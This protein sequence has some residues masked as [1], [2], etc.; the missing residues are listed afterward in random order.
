MNSSKSLKIKCQGAATQS[1]NELKDLQGGLKKLSKKNLEK[2]KKRIVSSG[3]CAPFFIW[4]DG[5]SLRIIDGHQR[6][7]ALLSLEAD[8]YEI[9]PLP[10]DYIH[11]ETEEEAKEILLSV[12]SQYGEWVEDELAEWIEN[13][14]DELKKSLRL[15]DKEMRIR[16]SSTIGDNDVPEEV[17]PV[18][19]LG[20]LYELNGHR[21]LCGDSTI[22]ENYELLL[23]GNLINLLFTDPPYGVDYSK[24]NEYLNQMDKG[25]RIQKDIK[26]DTESPEET[27]KIWVSCFSNAVAFMADKSVYYICCAAGNELLY[28]MSQ[29]IIESGFKLKHQIIWVKNNHVLGRTD[30]NYKHEP[31][32]YGWKK[33]HQFYG[34]GAQ[35]FSV[36]NFD[37]PSQSDLHPTMKPVELIENAI[38]NSSKQSD[39]IADIFCGSGSTLI[40]AERTTRKAFC[41][42]LD[43]HYC[44]VI[45][46]RF[47]DWCEKNDKDCVIKRNGETI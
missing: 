10:V 1:L 39:I 16:P 41:M 46:Q 19:Q 11:A 25:N 34:G 3:F 30:Y 35:K 4:D 5:E 33:S 43:P 23:N 17:E 36:W 12:S 28:H 20:D 26:N 44:D 40:A 32:L 22:R 15:V 14:D 45:I 13:I 37:K 2:L 42:E 24:K 6:R 29:S 38:L 21:L 18:T 7:A 31:I 47:R 8:G 27:K 9:P